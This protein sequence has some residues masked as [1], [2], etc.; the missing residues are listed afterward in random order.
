MSLISDQVL[1]RS[2]G[3]GAIERG[4]LTVSRVIRA[5]VQDDG[6]IIGVTRGSQGQL[7]E[8]SIQSS[9]GGKIKGACTCPLSWNCKHCV[10][11][12]VKLGR[13]PGSVDRVVPLFEESEGDAPAIALDN[14]ALDHTTRQWLRSIKDAVTPKAKEEK[15]SPVQ[16]IL[17]LLSE[18]TPGYQAKRLY[19]NVVTVKHLKSGGFGVP[20]PYKIYQAFA[21]QFAEFISPDEAVLLTL[22]YRSCKRLGYSDSVFEIAGLDADRVLGMLLDTGKCH[23]EEPAGPLMVTGPARKLCFHWVSNQAGV[24]TL[25]MQPEPTGKLLRTSPAR[26]VDLQTGELGML[27]S[28]LTTDSMTA[29]VDAPE[30]K[31]ETADTV[32]QALI[33]SFPDR[34]DL[35][36]EA[37]HPPEVVHIAAV[38]ILAMSQ[39]MG[40]E[41]PTHSGVQTQARHFPT[42]RVY[43]EYGDQRIDFEDARSKVTL[44]RDGQLIQFVRDTHFEVECDRRLRQLGL[45]KITPQET[46]ARFNSKNDNDFVVP[47]GKL[48][49]SDLIRREL[50]FDFIREK[51]PQLES[52]GWRLE[53]ARD[54]QLHESTPEF[55]IDVEEGSIDWFSMSL[56]FEIE[57]E[58]VDLLPILVEAIRRLKWDGTLG[59][60]GGV[61]AGRNLYH[62]LKDGRYV[63]LPIER[64]APLVR[65]IYE[66]YGLET[67]LKGKLIVERSRIADLAALEAAA[68]GVQWQGSDRLRDLG[69]KLAEV[70][71]LPPA[72]PPKKLLGS[73]RP[74]QQQGLAWL[75]LLREFGFG[76]ILAD[77]M[78][79]G[80]TVQTISHI[81]VEKAAG[82]LDVPALIVAPTSTLPNWKAELEQFAPSLKVVYAQGS[83]RKKAFESLSKADVVLTTYPLLARDKEVLNQ[84]E[85][86]LLVLDEAQYIKNSKTTSWHAAREI[87]ARHKICLTGTP[88]ENHLGELWSLFEFLMPGF[89]GGSETF[90]RKF[91]TPIESHKNEVARERLASIVR[92]FMLRRTKEAVATELPPKTEVLERVELS[93]P[94]RDLYES[95][96]LAMSKRVRDEIASK[97]LAKSQIIVLDALL[98]LRQACCDPRLVKVEDAKGVEGSAKLD[99][100]VELLEE[101]RSEGR[102]ALVFSQFTTM[103]G[104]IG[105]RLNEIGIEFV[106]ITG[107]TKDRATPVKRFQK[108]EVPVF[109]IS[110]KAGGT[111]L[112]LTAAETVIHY[113]PWWNP[114]VERQATDRAHR[115]GQKKPVFVHKLVATDTVEE[116]IL[117]L[118]SRKADLAN[119]LLEGAENRKTAL[120]AEDIDL[121]FGE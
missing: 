96:R 59:G 31:P 90:K 79:L 109:L 86:H 53:V 1:Q 80:K 15:A 89:L 99:R 23:W 118:Q 85:Y 67:K 25:R 106:T 52:E 41:H 38:P 20:K 65:T 93:G 60:E 75:Q 26:Y 116:R 63:P 22:L 30:I 78:G 32:R 110:L 33:R 16:T 8:Q 4:R 61:D 19:V 39:Q 6:S 81:L 14:P 71:N 101:L 115:I 76:A 50:T 2:F 28:G 102:Q 113:D 114:A 37:I 34:P 84:T 42:F 62:K 91:R 51:G 82:R 47:V 66:W 44:S 121:F 36:P 119:A 104:F 74:Y 35:W 94:Q 68:E 98:K 12:I 29:L 92:P 55:R 24:Q 107:D 54:L 83:D 111:G 105:D 58:Q 73:L 88:M 77:D 120:A 45:S 5:N 70:G 69:R 9:T 13:L 40:F 56:G 27:D 7:Y 100:L 95:L 3:R 108:G 17:F 64:L 10:A 46:Q 72:A 49:D 48:P 43:F 18:Q 87:R 11:V 21:G 57:G 112:N 97:G 117:E 103:L